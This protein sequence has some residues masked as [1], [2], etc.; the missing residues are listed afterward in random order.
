MSFIEKFSIKKL[1]DDLEYWIFIHIGNDIVE[2]KSQRLEYKHLVEE[3]QKNQI[4][5]IPNFV[6][7]SLD[8]ELLLP[9]FKRR[10]FWHLVKL[11]IRRLFSWK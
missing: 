6:L 2:L 7:E 8:R 9:W 1:R 10:T 4:F 11:N 5:D 3:A